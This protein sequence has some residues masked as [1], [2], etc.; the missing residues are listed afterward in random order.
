MRASDDE[1]RCRR[2]IL[3]LSHSAQLL[4]KEVTFMLGSTTYACAIL[5]DVQVPTIKCLLTDGLTGSVPTKP[6]LVG[7][8]WYIASPPCSRFL[9][10]YLTMKS[11]GHR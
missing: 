2:V 11:K 5:R 3:L 9:T 8:Y 1:P 7:K 10:M 4:W 6:N